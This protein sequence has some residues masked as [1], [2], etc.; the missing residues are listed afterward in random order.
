MAETDT[1]DGLKII[2]DLYEAEFEDPPRFVVIDDIDLS[3]MASESIEYCPPDE[4]QQR[5]EEYLVQS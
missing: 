1:K 5:F 4:F 3:D 2:K